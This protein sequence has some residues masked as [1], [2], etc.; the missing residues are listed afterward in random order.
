M[1]HLN[2]LIKEFNPTKSKALS[3]CLY[4][5]SVR[6]LPHI[7]KHY[8]LRISLN[9]AKKIIKKEFLVHQNISDDY[10]VSV[11]VKKYR[12]LLDET[13][14]LWKTK[15]EVHEFFNINRF[16]QSKTLK[17]EEEQFLKEFF[18]NG[19]PRD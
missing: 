6:E 14:N 4:R 9:D 5:D 19:N 16:T 10:L 18:N 13:V 1:N 17:H 8:N 7:I 2:S 12:T 11:E 15:K 3:Q